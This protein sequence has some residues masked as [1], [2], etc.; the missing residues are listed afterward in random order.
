MKITFKKDTGKVYGISPDFSLSE[1]DIDTLYDF[2]SHEWWY[3]DGEVDEVECND[4]EGL[5][6]WFYSK[7]KDFQPFIDAMSEAIN[8]VLPPFK[9]WKTPFH[10]D[11]VV[12]EV[13]TKKLKWWQK[14]FR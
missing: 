1:D 9:T 5:V 3:G 8:I 11:I 2:A 12:E 10:T 7:P 13:K 14:L 4:E 6:L